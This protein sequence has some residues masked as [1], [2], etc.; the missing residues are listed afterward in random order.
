MPYRLAR[1]A[2]ANGIAKPHHKH[3]RRLNQVPE[4]QTG[5]FHVLELPPKPAQR[6][7]VG[8]HPQAERVGRQDGHD[9]AAK[10]VERDE[11][12]GQRPFAASDVLDR[13]LLKGDRGRRR[14]LLGG[15]HGG[16]IVAVPDFSGAVE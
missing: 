16:W 6:G 5:P 3:E 9:E 14:G 8:E 10:C 2:K 11:P 12:I 7:V 15:A 4:H 1:A 13:D